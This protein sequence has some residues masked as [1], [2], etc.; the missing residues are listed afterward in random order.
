MRVSQSLKVTLALAVVVLVA[1]A[2]VYF[3]A[4][5]GA[6]QAAAPSPVEPADSAAAPAV[7][8]ATA[9][10]RTGDRA[11]D[12]EAPLLDETGGKLRLSDLRGKAV[13]MNFWASWCGPCRAEARDLEAAYQRYKTQG[14]VFLG[15]D[16]EQD[17]WADAR[18]FV[19]EFAITYP[20]VRDV[21]GKITQT[22]EITAIPTTYFV[23]REGI[24]RDKY[25]GG[26]LGD[27]GKQTLGKR[28]EGLLAR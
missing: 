22:Y 25:T 17:T 21:S 5:K 10:V 7:P 24:V 28:I 1:V 16:I 26:F 3:V 13:V 6:E 2:F 19:K 11:P 9:G 23:D 18:A 8:N 12:F 4:P 15:V 27:L 14:V 20:T